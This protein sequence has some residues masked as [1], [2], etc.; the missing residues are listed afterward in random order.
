[1]KHLSLLGDAVLRVAAEDDT[2]HTLS[3]PQLLAR[4][5]A[6]DNLAFTALRPHQ[7]P[8]W[9]AFLVQLAFLALEAGAL[10]EPPQDAALWTNLLRALTPQHPGDEPWHLVVDDWTLP[11][12]MQSPCVAGAQGDYRNA[13]ASAQELDL[14]VTS[15]NHDEKIGKLRPVLPDEADVWAYA[16]LSLQGFAGFLGRGNFNTMRMNG[17]FGSRS[18]FRLVTQRGSGAEF[19]RDLRALLAGADALW[20]DAQ[21]MQIGTDGQAALLWL[22]TWGSAALP[23]QHVHPLCL[24]VTRR[25]RLR[26]CAL[27]GLEMLSAASDTMRVAAKDAKGLVQDPWTPVI[28]EGEPRALTAQADA[29]S[30]H[31]LAP[32][33]FD[34]TRC[35]LPLLARPTDAEIDS[36]AN[37]TLVAQVLVGGSGRTDGVLR[38]EVWMPTHVLRKF[39]TARGELAAR[40]LVFIELASLA[41]GRVL[42]AALLQFVD[43]SA[44]VNWQNK[45]FGKAVTPWVNL[46]EER[47]DAVFFPVLFQT[48]TEPPMSDVDARTTWIDVLAGLVQET[49]D[50]ALTALPTR[51]RTHHVARARAARL[52]AN[53]SR[54]HLQAEPRPELV[55]AA[56]KKKARGAKTSFTS[57]LTPTELIA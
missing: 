3:L 21:A 52:L 11:A 57:G 30:Y 51:D 40:A 28:K 44:A 14:L 56:A 23:L 43:G 26:R 54:T 32:L 1:M 15:K 13:A 36:H 46:L 35:Q 29:F 48:T 4:L 45:D 12:F 24:E 47:I 41:Q 25:V 50:A 6:G 18:Q 22:P 38:R 37:A 55:S 27:G 10:T 20:H 39:A 2:A 33:L 9:H 53:A 5:S 16:L 19:L 31:R 7:R 8:A 17:G 42:R 34:Y 49:F